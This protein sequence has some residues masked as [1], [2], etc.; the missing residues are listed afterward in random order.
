MNWSFEY[1]DIFVDHFASQ[2]W[3]SLAI[4]LETVVD[5]LS[6]GMLVAYRHLLQLSL[7]MWALRIACSSAME[8]YTC[9]RLYLSQT[10][11]RISC[12]DDSKHQCPWEISA[13]VEDIKV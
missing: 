9:L 10:A 11:R 3:L 4:L 6:C 12:I 7:K 1:S 2:L 5:R 13:L 8:L